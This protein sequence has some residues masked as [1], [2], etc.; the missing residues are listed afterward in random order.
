MSP[1]SSNG[2]EWFTAL[3]PYRPPQDLPARP[4]DPRL[5]E[6]TEFWSGGAPGLAGGRAV[7]IGFPCDEGV[8]RN[9]GRPGAAG[10]PASIRKFLYRLTPWDGEGRL[11]LRRAKPLDLGDVRP[12]GVLEDAQK[13]LGA[14]V[15]AVLRAGAVP[16]VLGGGHETAFGHYLGYVE[17]NIPVGIIN[18]DAHLDVRPLIE[19]RGHSGSPF[20]QMMEHDQAPLPGHRYICIGAQ[21]HAVSREH[22]QYVLER[23]GRIHWS[24]PLQR[25]LGEI[26]GRELER[27]PYLPCQG[28]VSLDADVVR[29]ADVP[30]VS[31]P[32]PLGLPGIELADC[33]RLAGQCPYVSSFEIVE[34]NPLVDRDDQSS[35]WGALTVWQFLA[36]LAQRVEERDR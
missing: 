26:F 18:L 16:I 14:V 1:A 4:D 3:E 22:E 11:D 24:A 19:C 23:G 36:G 25:N 32:N 21:P 31:A 6:V 10:A 17:A 8:R 35:R 34:I 33:A 28:Y 20:R 27:L 12:G 5:H 2:G 7:I 13:Q 15:G 29:A 9:S 30:G